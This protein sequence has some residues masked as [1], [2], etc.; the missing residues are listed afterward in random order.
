MFEISFNMGHYTNPYDPDT[1][2]VYAVF[3]GPGGQ[4]DTVQGFYYEGYTFQQVGDY[5]LA[6]RDSSPNATGWRV[7]F[8]PTATGFWS[9][10]IR[11]VDR[12]GTAVYQGQG[13]H[14]MCMFS[15]L[16][17]NDA[18]GFISKA[19]NQYLKRDIVKNGNRQFHS[20]FPIGPDIAWYGYHAN[21]SQPYGIYEY[22]RYIDSLS[23][24]ANYMRLFLNR[25]HHLNLY[26][27]EYTQVENG[28]PV[29]YFDSTLNQKDAA[30]LDYILAY[31]AQ[32]DV[33]V[34]LSFLN[35]GDFKCVNNQD[36][37]DPSIWSHNPY[38][39]VLGLI[40]PQSFLSDSNARKITKNL[41][42]Y[43]LARWG[44][45]TNILGWEF[46]NE[47]NGMDIS[48]SVSFEDQ[49]LDWHEDMA[50]FVRANDPFDHCISTSMGAI[51][52]FQNL[53]SELYEHL[54]FVQEHRYEHIQNA[55]S[56]SQLLHRILY[57]TISGHT[58][59]PMLPFFMGEF[60]F[61]SSSG[62]TP[63]SKDP[64][65]F[66]LHNSLW[67]SLFSG[68]MGP[69]SF[70]WWHYLDD[71]CLFKRFAPLLTF[72]NN[73]PILSDSFTAHHTGDTIGHSLVFPNNLETYYLINASEDTI[74]GWC[75]D[76]AFAY[77]SLRW[78]TDSVES[79]STQWGNLLRFKNNVVYDPYGYVYTMDPLKRPGPSSNKNTI[80]LPI[81][82]QPEGARYLVKWFDSETGVAINTGVTIHATVHQDALGNRHVSF[83]FPS[84]IRNLQQHTINNRFGDAVFM[85]TYLD[86]EP[87]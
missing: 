87:L 61:G 32:H 53:Y 86:M 25:Y 51:T 81:T 84:V 73:L 4:I 18:S 11:A 30:E 6:T 66:D 34:M 22:E 47:V 77:T 8:T 33:T 80:T 85:L 35:C 28:Q 40:T 16:A 56:R 45:A 9:F 26:G 12:N 72:C 21:Y 52:G 68:S 75:Q 23:G 15:C 58:A 63:N 71:R 14:P 82:N 5:E 83:K 55:E 76:T 3:S 17:V 62:I 1:I 69:A 79:V 37:S 27:P 10:L 50:G 36:P 43:I 74:Y 70:W 41:F 38:H 24:N 48:N 29:V 65:G 54:D 31:A 19:N 57:R 42:R 39:T 49:V 67:A 64:W 59:F 13:L 7:R 60:G 44:Y 20:F 78:L 46:W 2:M